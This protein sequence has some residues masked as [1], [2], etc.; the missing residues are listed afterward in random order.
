MYGGSIEHV[1]VDLGVLAAYLVV[2][3]AVSTS[4]ARSAGSWSA[5]RIKPELAL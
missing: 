5:R 2:A 1:A 3:F 4:A